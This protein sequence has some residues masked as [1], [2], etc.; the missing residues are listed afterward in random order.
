L[1]PFERLIINEDHT[2][3]SK[4]LPLRRA[5]SR[6]LTENLICKGYSGFRTLLP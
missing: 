3:V 5:I 2:P 4:T 1:K 6:Q